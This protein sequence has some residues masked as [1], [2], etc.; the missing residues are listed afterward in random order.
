MPKLHPTPVASR[1]S[2]RLSSVLLYAAAL[3][4]ACAPTT[5]AQP[6]SASTNSAQN[7][8]TEQALLQSTKAV[9]DPMPAKLKTMLLDDIASKG[10][11]G[12]LESCSVKG[13][14]AAK[15]ASEKTGWTIR[16]VS[17][18]NRNPNAVPDAWETKQIQALE[19]DMLKGSNPNLEKW[20]VVQNT[21]K[22]KT[23]RYVKG[24][25]TSAECLLCH[26]DTATM[27]AGAIA[28]IHKLYPQDK[29][30]GYK[31]GQLRGVL[32]VV[33]PL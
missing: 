28:S 7:T 23:F 30:T 27:D 5:P 31:D 4:S 19:A 33:R 10:I 17:L 18:K 9:V 21:D 11:A 16:R 29:A 12:G 6:P 8:V 3:C 13:P 32:S 22:S 25:K 15:Q 24:L 14:A 26:G 1:P 2:I 20:E